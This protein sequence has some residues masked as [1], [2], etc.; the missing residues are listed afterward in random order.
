MSVAYANYYVA[1]RKETIDWTAFA[2]EQGDNRNNELGQAP[3]V[4]TCRNHPIH[5]LFSSLSITSSF[6]VGRPSLPAVDFVDLDWDEE[7]H[8]PLPPAG[9]CSFFFISH[10]YLLLRPFSPTV[11]PSNLPT[12]S[13]RH[14][15]KASLPLP[16]LFP[17]SPSSPFLPSF[18]SS[19]PL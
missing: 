10:R 4:R 18:P 3:G 14:H 8:R 11:S 6:C 2:R 1:A 19:S 13:L 7:I 15:P 16:P 17:P 12:I 5:S 9:F